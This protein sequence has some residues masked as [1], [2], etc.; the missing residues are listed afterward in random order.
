MRYCDEIAD[1]GGGKRNKR[2]PATRWAKWE[3]DSAYSTKL[4]LLRMPSELTKMMGGWKK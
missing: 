1:G 2:A 3:K 4:K